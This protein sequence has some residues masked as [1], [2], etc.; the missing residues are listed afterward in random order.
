MSPDDAANPGLGEIEDNRV[1]GQVI[2]FN[3]PYL[4]GSE[5]DRM[6]QAVQGLVISEGGPFTDQCERLLVEIT[7]AAAALL[8]SSC[9]HALEMVA[10][11]LELDEGDE[12]VIPSFT[13][14]STA[15]AFALRGA[16]P[17]F[18][19]IRPDTLNIDERSLGSKIT[20]RT[21]AI[22]VVHYAGVGCE[23]ESIQAVADEAGVPIIEDNAHGLLGS[24]RGK[25]LGTPMKNNLAT[26]V[27]MA[28]DTETAVTSMPM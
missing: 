20:S 6:R 4:V 2:P 12:V 3:R 16:R 18:A 19:D 25:P 21:R 1:D 8:T 11:L 27:T 17:V 13:F 28:A 26:R 14:V 22:V 15:N 9:T 23:M 5:F 7:G 10:I 24:Y